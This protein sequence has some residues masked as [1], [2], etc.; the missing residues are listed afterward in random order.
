[1]R[2][3]EEQRLELQGN[4]GDTCWVHAGGKHFIR[5]DPSADCASKLYRRLSRE[6]STVKQ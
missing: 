1:M 5:K 3:H 4:L 6:K 2:G